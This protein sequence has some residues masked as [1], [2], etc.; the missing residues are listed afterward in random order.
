[1]ADP[2]HERDE[3]PTVEVRVYRHGVLVHQELCESEEQAA[4]VVEEW[5]DL[6][7]VSCEVDNLT[8]HNHPD[9]ALEPGAD[10]AE[11]DYRD[12]RELDSRARLER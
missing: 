12:Q 2:F 9:D 4:L 5:S 7:G 1:M 8:P 6:D 11:E 3:N 10:L